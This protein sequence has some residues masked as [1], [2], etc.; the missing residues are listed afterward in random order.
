MPGGILWSLD[1]S[2]FEVL[3]LR[4]IL[5]SSQRFERMRIPRSRACEFQRVHVA[6]CSIRAEGLGFGVGTSYTPGKMFPYNYF[7]A[8][9]VLP[10]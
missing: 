10:L 7:R 5:E 9:V 3:H 8:K 4:D 2:S 1:Y 6:I